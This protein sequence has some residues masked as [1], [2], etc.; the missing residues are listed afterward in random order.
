R[1]PDPDM[2]RYLELDELNEWIAK[3]DERIREERDDPF[4][5]GFEPE[6]WKLVDDLLVDGNKV[7]LD[8]TR[9]ARLMPDGQA[10]LVA[11]VPKEIEGAC[12]IWIPGANRS[13]KSE[14]AGKK[15]LK[16][17][18]DNA[19]ARTWSFAD[20]GPISIARQ[21]PIFWKYMPRDVKVL[22]AETG[23]A[24]FGVT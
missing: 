8:L 4:R 14:Y 15:I 13:S 23:K 22:A 16:V 20:T 9:I 11:D 7:V 6:V 19:N 2:V 18:N 3:F 10:P 5:N 24:R 17:L 12:E 21:Q 1:L